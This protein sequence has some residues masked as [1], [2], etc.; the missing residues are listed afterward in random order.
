M[1]RT[2]LGL[3]AFLL[4]GLLVLVWGTDSD[5]CGP[6]PVIRGYLERGFWQPI[7]R[8]AFH[9]FRDQKTPQKPG[10]PF[11]GFGADSGNR[12]LQSARAAYRELASECL[13]GTPETEPSGSFE[14]GRK[15]IQKALA[16]DP[17]PEER[18]ELEL[19][20]AKVDLREAECTG[21][22]PILLA[23]ARV[24]LESFIHSNPA[25]A[26]ASEARGWLGRIFFLTGDHV[27]AAKIYL[28]EFSLPDSVHSKDSLILSLRLIYPH[29]GTDR[30]LS[31]HLDEFFDTPEHALFAVTL[32]TNP[33]MDFEGT[34]PERAE[35][36]RRIREAVKRHPGLFGKSDA[37]DH[38]ALALMRAA[39]FSGDE[40]AALQS[41]RQVR[42]GSATTRNPD[43]LWMLAAAHHLTKNDREAREAFLQLTALPDLDPRYLVMGLQG[44][45]VSAGSLGRYE[46]Q[47]DASL[48][49]VFLERQLTQAPDVYNTV[50]FDL[51][52][53][54]DSKDMAY[55]IDIELP[56]EVLESY[57][58][59][60]WPSQ[61]L[62]FMNG[63]LMDGEWVDMKYSGADLVRYSLAV[64][65]ARVERY[66]DAER[67]YSRARSWRRVRRMRRISELH[68][69][70]SAPEA[71]SGARL[72]YAEFLAN[73]STQVFFN[74]RIWNG[75]Q[76]YVLATE[77]TCEGTTE[78]EEDSHED[79][80]DDP[81]VCARDRSFLDAQEEYWRAARLLGEIAR[82]ESTGADRDRAA[83][84]GIWSLSRINTERFGREKE[85][86]SLRKEFLASLKKPSS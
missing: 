43:F 16:A 35:I 29:D 27:R 65:Y 38:L 34:L 42:G 13:G 75:V 52:H 51:F 21:N 33:R 80:R 53:W 2:V 23:A 31:E 44:L 22:D 57:L 50:D 74:D 26:L 60:K 32:V 49:H 62:V 55:L 9:L 20:S 56:V 25:A 82:E 67:L 77:S 3:T 83:R 48:R 12:A 81:A 19:L 14:K 15:A 5:G 7:T 78:P 85:I 6:L 70:A 11:A 73:H 40:A 18:A 76:R 28:D 69:A 79:L 86:T 1:K 45:A 39:L 63:A 24:K 10:N 58:K 84:K 30:K 4:T 66:A 47:L 36:A 61:S 72:A 68:R 17:K 8:S 54:R 41:A 37:S 71:G 59:G 46:E 64:R